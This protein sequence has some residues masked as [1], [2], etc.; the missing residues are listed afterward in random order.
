M[1]VNCWNFK[2]NIRAF[3]EPK[4]KGLLSYAAFILLILVLSQ[5]LALAWP[6]RVGKM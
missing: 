3:K 5:F 2:Q 6:F 4:L 1:L